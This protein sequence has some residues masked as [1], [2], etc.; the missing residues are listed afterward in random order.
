MQGATSASPLAVSQYA[1]ERSIS[2]QIVKLGLM[3]FG[4]LLPAIALAD[5]LVVTYNT[6]DGRTVEIVFE[7][8]EAYELKNVKPAA[9]NELINYELKNVLP[10]P[11]S[12]VING[13]IDGYEL[14]NVKPRPVT[15]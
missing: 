1:I 2:M 10:V 7:P 12:I 6:A 15:K 5:E 11:G 14:K 3:L 8:K 4:L 13:Q 9:G